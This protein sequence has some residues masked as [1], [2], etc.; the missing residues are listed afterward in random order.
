MISNELPHCS[1]VL[2]W[3]LI[4]SFCPAWRYQPRRLIPG[5]GMNRRAGRGRGNW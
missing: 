3:R 1:I 5:I 4:G 2:S